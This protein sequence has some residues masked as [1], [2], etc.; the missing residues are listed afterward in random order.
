MRGELKVDI[1]EHIGVLS[2]KGSGW[3]KELNVVSWNGGE[4][5][6][7]IREWSEDHSRMGK[8]VTLTDEEAEKLCLLLE[9]AL[10]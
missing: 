5:K 3:K 1:R 7:D 8:G 9:E 4:Y 6:F 2:E 10:K